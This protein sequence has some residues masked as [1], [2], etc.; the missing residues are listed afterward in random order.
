MSNLAESLDYF[1]YE[2]YKKW[3]DGVRCELI[4]GG[5]N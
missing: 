1:T 3:K 2:K 5:A 4:Y